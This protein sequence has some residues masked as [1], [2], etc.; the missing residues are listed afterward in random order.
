MK[1]EW[2]SAFL[3]SLFIVVTTL[4]V[5]ACSTSNR[6]GKNAGNPDARQSVT[7]LSA[8][9]E[10]NPGETQPQ[11]DKKT[12]HQI[13]VQRDNDRFTLKV[14]PGQKPYGLVSDIQ[15]L[16]WIAL[17]GGLGIENIAEGHDHLEIIRQSEKNEVKSKGLWIRLYYETYKPEQGM[18][19]F[20]HK[21]IIVYAAP[22]NP[23]DA[24]L[25]IQNTDDQTK[26]SLFSLPGYGPWLKKEIDILLRLATGL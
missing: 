4:T 2:L 15:N 13:V 5:S 10:Q 7:P 18:N 12:L 1:K 16:R 23:N 21:D 26:W 20:G 11:Q 19:D 24:F 25:G 17:R 6:A 8:E 22:R 9:T 14:T 3:L